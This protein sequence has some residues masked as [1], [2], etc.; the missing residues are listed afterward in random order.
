MPGDQPMQNPPPLGGLDPADLLKQGVAD[1]TFV[2]GESSSFNP[3]SIEEL[4]AI[5]PQ[6]EILELIGKGGMG[7]VYKVR[8]KDLDRTV[9]LKILPPAIGRSP[10][11]SNRF[12]REARALAKLNHPGIVTLHEFGQQDGLYFILMEFVDGVN[13]A[14]LMK[15]GRISPREALAIVPQICDALQFAHDQGI[16]HRDI[17]PENILIDRL[18]RVKVAD[19][20]IAKVVA[21]VCDSRTDDEVRRSQ[22]AATTD[23]TLAGKI[24]GT[25]AYMAPEQ[26]SHPADVDHRADIYALG[27]VFYQ[28]LTGELPGKRLEAPSTKVHIDIRLDEIVLRAMEKDPELRYQQASVMRTRVDDL[29]VVRNL[30]AEG[31]SLAGHSKIISSRSESIQPNTH[32]DSFAISSLILAISSFALGPFGSLPAVILGHRSLSRIRTNPLLTGR[33]F[34]TGGLVLGYV[35]LVMCLLA[36]LFFSLLMV[37]ASVEAVKEPVFPRGI[38]INEKEPRVRP[39][40]VVDVLVDGKLRIDGKI[41][42][43]EE[44]LGKLKSIATQFP[45]RAVIIRSNDQTKYEYMVRVLNQCSQAHIG[46]VSFATENAQAEQ[47]APVQAPPANLAE[48]YVDMELAAAKARAAYHEGDPDRVAVENRLKLLLEKHPELPNEQSRAVAAQRQVALV[49][50]VNGLSKEFG[51]GH[52][53]IIE[54]NRQMEALSH[55][56]EFSASQLASQV[57]REILTR[58]LPPGNRL[59]VLLVTTGS[60]AAKVVKYE[61][62]GAASEE[63]PVSDKVIVCDQHIQQ[64][65]LLK[66]DGGFDLDIT[67]NEVGAQRLAEATKSNFGKNDR[68]SLAILLDGKVKCAPVWCGQLGKRFRISGIKNF[69]EYMDLYR[70]FPCW[71]SQKN[72]LEAA[73]WLLMVDDGK[74][75]ESYAAAAKLVHQKVTAK[76]W[77]VMFTTMRQPLGIVTSRG[78]KKCQE[79]KSLPGVPDGDYRLMLFN[80]SFANKR[81]AVETVTFVKEDDGVWRAAGYF[82]R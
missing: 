67:L 33:G 55:L 64:V 21:A 43:D 73:R 44:F 77:E 30:D 16:V 2:D 56:P 52:P 34:A 22:T 26:I 23:V 60:A 63:I 14:Q 27:V 80:T 71:E 1:D 19:F 24:I 20:G 32:V 70:S 10:E 38:V 59:E 25:P 47:V 35:N 4:A 41:M 3:P 8:Q 36:L 48:E 12:T 61:L 42:S 54:L 37:R 46:N 7:A 53:R 72:S 58:D 40:T 29:G 66:A 49:N 69:D 39:E 6:F 17:K 28:M 9:A 18:G 57:A 50:E 65:G 62:E 78:L 11:F 79:V 31:Q 81:E 75:A 5:F 74:Y 13:L 15:T 76:Q 51:P 45:N 82:I 68:T